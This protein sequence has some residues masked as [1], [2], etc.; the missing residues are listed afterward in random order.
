MQALDQILSGLSTF[1]SS[2]GPVLSCQLLAML[3]C[4]CRCIL[5]QGSSR[6][7]GEEEWW[8]QGP[9]QQM[10]VCEI[11]EDL[12]ALVGAQGGHKLWP[13][14]L[15]C[16]TV[17]FRTQWQNQWHLT[18]FSSPLITLIHLALSTL[19]HDWQELIPKLNGSAELWRATIEELVVLAGLYVG[20]GQYDGIRFMKFSQPLSVQCWA[21]KHGFLWALFSHKN[22]RRDPSRSVKYI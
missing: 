7:G 13:E 2:S 3:S 6:D 19:W 5:R 17:M 1:C 22:F 15:S 8:V 18:T 21:L 11:A 16:P 14:W 20:F 4:F 9:A 10:T 12:S